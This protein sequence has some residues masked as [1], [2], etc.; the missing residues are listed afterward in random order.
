MILRVMITS[1][2]SKIRILDGHEVVCKYRG[3]S[4]FGNQMSAAFIPQLENMYYLLGRTLAFI[5]GNIVEEL[6]LLAAAKNDNIVKV[7]MLQEKLEEKDMKIRRIKKELEQR[8]VKEE[9]HE[10]PITTVEMNELSFDDK[11]ATNELGC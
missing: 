5:S 2:D 6:R 10:E 9:P 8:G 4:K 3:L 11:I 7:F 1:G